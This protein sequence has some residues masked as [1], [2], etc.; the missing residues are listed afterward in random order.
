MTGTL[1]A[2]VCGAALV[3][4]VGAQTP[5]PQVRAVEDVRIA[6][7]TENGVARLHPFAG[8]PFTL[9]LRALSFS[10]RPFNAFRLDPSASPQPIAVELGRPVPQNYPGRYEYI[11]PIT[12]PAPAGPGMYRLS[13]DA[14]PGFARDAG[15]NVLPSRRFPKSGIGAI[16]AWW[17]DER[18]G[19]SGLRDVRTRF[20]MR[21]VRTYG[22]IALACP[23]WGTS[24]NPL[25]AIGV[26]TVTREVGRVEELETGATWDAQ[27]FGF[28][29]LAFDPL[30]F[31]V[32]DPHVPRRRCPTCSR[33]ISCCDSPTRGASIRR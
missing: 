1:R 25:V 16:A 31:P 3:V 30:A 33:A 2:L 26:G 27:D 4:A 14:L 29:F 32:V 7:E 8:V 10:L 12:V 20:S 6:F 24:T 11:I 5:R 15:G 28:R 23:S 21:A 9:D 19:D 18:G 13:A 22:G 17:P